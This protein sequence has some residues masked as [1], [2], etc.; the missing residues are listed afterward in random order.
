METTSKEFLSQAYHIN[1]EIKNL[2]ERLEELRSTTQCM[3]ASYGQ[4]QVNHTRNVTAMQD[5]IY[6]MMEKCD[7]IKQEVERL[8][9]LKMQVENVIDQVKNP[10]Y[11]LILSWRYLFS[12]TWEQIA[13]EMGYS[14]RWVHLN[15]DR[16]LKVVD[17][18]IN[19]TDAC[20]VKKPE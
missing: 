6:S 11:R 8:V 4:E 17:R 15:H 12:W 3:T 18:L 2:L 16:A 20:S 14:A 5:A 7:E 1:K 10:T 13:D 9:G 19:D